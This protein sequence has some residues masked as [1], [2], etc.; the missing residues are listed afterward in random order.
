MKENASGC[1]FLNTVYIYCGCG[2]I[3]PF[4]NQLTYQLGGTQKILP[5]ESNFC[6]RER[7]AQNAL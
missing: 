5:D 6:A 2:L 4:D 1:F 3:Y 7:L